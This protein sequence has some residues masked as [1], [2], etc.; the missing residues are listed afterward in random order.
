MWL[1]GSGKT[2]FSSFTAKRSSEAPPDKLIYVISFLLG[3]LRGRRAAEEEVRIQREKK[4]KKRTGGMMDA[5]ISDAQN[6]Q[7]SEK[8]LHTH[9]PPLQH[10]ALK[11][12]PKTKINSAFSMIFPRCLP[13]RVS[14][15]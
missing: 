14:S 7:W 1:E 10:Y 15:K 3:S 6:S 11:K 5:E 4:R 9:F 13:N 2:A 8:A 12:G